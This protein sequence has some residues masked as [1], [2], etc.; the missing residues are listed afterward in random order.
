MDLQN[1]TTKQKAI[2]LTVVILV[3]AIYLAFTGMGVGIFQ[4]SSSASENSFSSNDT[5]EEG[6]ATSERKYYEITGQVKS[7]GVYEGEDQMMVVELISLAGG[8]TDNADLYII[9]K[10]ISLSAI[11]EDRQKIYIPAVFERSA[12]GSLSQTQTNITGT[13]GSQNNDKV[14]INNSTS[15]ELES[16]PDIGPATSA[17]IIGARPFGSL[18]DLKK[19][20]GIGEKTYNNIVSLISL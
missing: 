1:L 7:P 17:K 13:A 6:K 3:G 19:V 10:D 14:S 18:E 2:I 9:H 20:Q 8:L 4:E 15:Q 11:V 12:S 16:L 5:S